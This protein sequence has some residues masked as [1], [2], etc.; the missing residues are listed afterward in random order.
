MICQLIG[1]SFEL[2]RDKEDEMEAVGVVGLFN[3]ILENVQGIESTIPGVVQL[4]IAELHQAKTSD[5]TTTL[6]EGVCMCLWYDLSSTL[7]TLSA[8]GCHENVF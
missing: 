7:N 8:A 1:K 2:A 5:Y 4:Y 3:S 6:L